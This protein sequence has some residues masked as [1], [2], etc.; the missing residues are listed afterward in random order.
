MNKEKG[1]KKR[2]IFSHFIGLQSLSFIV[3]GFSC[4]CVGRKER[5]KGRPER[6]SSFFFH[7]CGE[8]ERGTEKNGKKHSNQNDPSK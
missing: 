2:K 8:G 4:F 7:I 6:F 1:K 3:V 5:K